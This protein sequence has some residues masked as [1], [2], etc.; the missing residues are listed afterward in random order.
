MT[1]S[2]CRSKS[3]VPIRLCSSVYFDHHPLASKQVEDGPKDPGNEGTR[4]DNDVVW[5]TE[6]GRREIDEQRACVNSP[7]ARGCNMCC[8]PVASSRNVPNGLSN[9]DRREYCAGDVPPALRI[10]RVLSISKEGLANIHGDVDRLSR[11]QM[12]EGLQCRRASMRDGRDVCEL[13]EEVV[14]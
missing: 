8:M 3:H 11:W 10:R 14:W 4:E 1:L 2:T 9:G 7:F 5:H 13:R 12:Q 6:V